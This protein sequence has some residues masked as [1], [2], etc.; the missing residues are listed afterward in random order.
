MANLCHFYNALNYKNAEMKKKLGE[1]GTISKLNKIFS[2]FKD[3][4]ILSI[5]TLKQC[6]K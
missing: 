3:H 1:N 2:Y 6:F 5:N 4:E